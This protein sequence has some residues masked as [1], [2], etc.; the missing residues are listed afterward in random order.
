MAIFQKPTKKET[1]CHPS[2]SFCIEIFHIKCTSNFFYGILNSKVKMN[3]NRSSRK[4][5]RATISDVARAAGV[6]TTTVSFVLNH[7]PGQTI[8]LGTRIRVFE[9]SRELGY[10]PDPN[11]RALGKGISNEIAHISFEPVQAFSMMEWLTRIQERTLQL[12]YFPE[13][14]LC[15]AGSLEAMSDK[16]FSIL[17]RN[18]IGLLGSSFSLSKETVTLAKNMGVR[19]CVVISAHQEDYAPTVILPY[20]EAGR[21]IGIHFLERRHRCLAF[22]KPISPTPFRSTA[23]KECLRG[24]HSVLA[25]SEMN[26]IEFPMDTTLESARETVDKILNCQEKPTAVFGFTDDYSLP[27]HKAFQERGVRMPNDIAMVGSEDTELSNYLHPTLTAVRF[28]VQTLAFQ[29][30]DLADALIRDQEPS[31]ELLT[32]PLPQLIIRESSY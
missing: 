18:P 11:A 10:L 32:S 7:T 13:T 6:S 8:S 27:L 5:K 28:D 23:S 26:L 2:L 16:I 22:I 31:P 1:V 3:Q 12:E 19:V 21:L 20:E 30:V 17:A 24:I 15:Y 9:A 14:Y 29:C 4:I 25:Q